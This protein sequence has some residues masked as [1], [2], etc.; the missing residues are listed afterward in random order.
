[1]VARIAPRNPAITRGL[2]RMASSDGF[3]LVCAVDHVDEIRAL[4]PA[5]SQEFSHLVQA[6]SEL[7]RAVSSE[8]SG[9]L[10]DSHHGA[11]YATVGGA[12]GPELGLAF[13]LEHADYSDTGPK[14]TQYREGWSVAG[15]VRGGADAVKLLWW[16]R[17]DL[18]A[19]QAADQERF[20]REVVAECGRLGIGLI[21]EPIWYP[22]PGE[23]MADPDWQA[24]RTRGVIESAIFADRI[25]ASLLK[26]QFPVLPSAPD[27]EAQARKALAEIDA[28]VSAPWVILSA[29]V[30][31]EAFRTQ[32]EWSA[33]AGAS[34]Y[35][36]GRSLWRDA[37]VAAA[38]AGS[39]AE[40]EVA[41]AGLRARFAELN[42][43]VREHG[44]PFLPARDDSYALE[45]LPEGWYRG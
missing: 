2:Q 39:P 4:L 32:V 26:L 24:A 20:A 36:A 3:F 30:D 23:D 34:G 1:M 22:A 37:M 35:I 9:V 27:Y 31:Y 42:D 17:P 40:A 6:K 13:A 41:Y 25:G 10:I 44:R 5:S 28:A 8:L 33:A 7:L 11:G 12:V 16:Y 21:L 14:V 38:N 18:D 45:Q 29:G 19:E 43:L 15:A